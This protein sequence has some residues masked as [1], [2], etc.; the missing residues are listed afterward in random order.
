MRGVNTGA[1]TL[2]KKNGPFEEEEEE[3]EGVDVAGIAFLARLALTEEVSYL[4]KIIYDTQ[5]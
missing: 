2:F 3:M 4:R 5:T 1:K